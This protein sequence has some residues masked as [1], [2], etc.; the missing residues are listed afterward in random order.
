MSEIE[1]GITKILIATKQLLECL[2][3]WSRKETTEQDVSD[4]YVSLGNEFNR[5]T[6]SF[7][8]AGIDMT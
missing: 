6:L 2:T 7:Q 4:V 3:Q 5:A 8:N 1:S